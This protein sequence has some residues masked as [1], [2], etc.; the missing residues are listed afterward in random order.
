MKQFK[1]YFYILRDDRV[2]KFL[3]VGVPLFDKEPHITN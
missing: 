1:D 3:G 2:Q